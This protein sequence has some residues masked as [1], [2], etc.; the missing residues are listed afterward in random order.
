MIIYYCKIYNEIKGMAKRGFGKDA[1]V[2]Y[3]AL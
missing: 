2:R 1:G 3:T